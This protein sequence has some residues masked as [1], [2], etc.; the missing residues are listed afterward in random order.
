MAVAL[1]YLRGDGGCAQP[2]ALTNLLFKLRLQMGECSHCAREFSHAYLFCG[3]L[4]TLNVAYRFGVPVSQLQSKRSRLGMDAVGS[5]NRGRV[6]KLMGA[7]RQHLLQVFQVI[8][9]DA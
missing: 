6:L 8:S 3:P 1:N 7:P 2:Q 5:S 4:E 9:D